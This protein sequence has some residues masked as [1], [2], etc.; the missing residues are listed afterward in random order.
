VEKGAK[1][2]HVILDLTTAR[3]RLC[4]VPSAP[5]QLTLDVRTQLCDVSMSLLDAER[6]PNRTTNLIQPHLLYTRYQ[7][8][9]SH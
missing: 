4:T 2:G 9:F 3:H 7:S 8:A 1:C 6:A 5:R